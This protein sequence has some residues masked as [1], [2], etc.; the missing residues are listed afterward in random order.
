MTERSDYDKRYRRK[1]AKR[2]LLRQ[3][4][5]TAA[6]LQAR[7]QY[8]SPF[9]FESAD[10]QTPDPDRKKIKKSFL[11]R[12]RDILLIF[13]SFL[14]G[15][16]WYAIEGGK[17]EP[18]HYF[19]H[20]KDRGKREYL[21]VLIIRIS[22]YISISVILAVLIGLYILPQP[23]DL[24]LYSVRSLV[25]F[26]DHIFSLSYLYAFSASPESPDELITAFFLTIFLPYFITGLI[27]GI[28][29][30]DEAKDIVG[31]SSVLSLLLFLFFYFSQTVLLSSSTAQVP[32][33]FA[34]WL[35]SG[36]YIAL[37]A[38]LVLGF[39]IVSMIGGVLGVLLGKLLSNIAFAKQ[40][41]KVGYSAY[42]LPEMPVTVKTLF[43][44]VEIT[45][46]SL[47]KYSRDITLIYLGQKVELTSKMYDTKVC[48]Y[49]VENRCSYLGYVTTGHRLQICVT[50]LHNTCRV[51]AFILQSGRLISQA[52]KGEE[53][54]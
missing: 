20:M 54:G 42:I 46:Q 51:F 47:Q 34:S 13:F 5:S 29:W 53:N 43:D 37:L 28:L 22:T 18:E 1:S 40:G 44:M 48:P 33:V 11:L 32:N 31:P 7:G 14:V 41:A 2:D 9:Y 52:N 36:V 10:D 17:T 38:F 49:F 21:T 45:G 26:P 50:E 12:F 30:K 15:M 19:L 24:E 39:F 16:I 4:E 8:L 27:S 23:V 6:E 25:W 35:L 3:T